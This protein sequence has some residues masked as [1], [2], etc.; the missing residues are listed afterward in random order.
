MLIG[1]V[2]AIGPSTWE[3]TRTDDGERLEIR[4]TGDTVIE[5]GLRVGDRVRVKTIAAADGS[6]L[7]LEIKQAEEAEPEGEA[8][9]AGEDLGAQDSEGQGEYSGSSDEATGDGEA[10]GWDNSESADAEHG[11]GDDGGEDHQQDH[12]EGQQDGGHDGDHE[13]DD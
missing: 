4:I 9:S 1:V 10:Q 11:E 7:D 3:I 13:G 8:P 5:D 6:Y 2:D 12:H